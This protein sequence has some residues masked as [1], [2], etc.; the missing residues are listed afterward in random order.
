MVYEV[1][2]SAGRVGWA[3]RGWIPFTYSTGRVS[4]A[5]RAGE[6]VESELAAAFGPLV[7]SLGQHVADESDDAGLVGED[8]YHVGTSADPAVQSTRWVVRPDL[9]HRSLGVT[10]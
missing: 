3:V 4:A 6:S 8:P 7:V 10:G 1:D 5:L 2:P 9:A